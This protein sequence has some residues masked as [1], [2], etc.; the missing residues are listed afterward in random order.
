MAS[1]EEV[2]SST[3]EAIEEYLKYL[4]ENISINHSFKKRWHQES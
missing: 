3:E 2:K 4:F 1:L